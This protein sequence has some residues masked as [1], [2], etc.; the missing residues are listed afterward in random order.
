MTKRTAAP[1]CPACDRSIDA[2][3]REEMIACSAELDAKRCVLCGSERPHDDLRE[4][5]SQDFR[6][7]RI[8]VHICRDGRACVDRALAAHSINKTEAATR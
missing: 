2:H 6:G 4:H 3:T 7:Q 8:V 1:R 5:V